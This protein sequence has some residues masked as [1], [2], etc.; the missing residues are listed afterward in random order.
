[1]EHY[2]ARRLEEAEAG[3]RQIL[4]RDPNDEHAAQILARVLIDT[5]RPEQALYMLERLCARRPESPR[6]HALRARALMLQRRTEEAL[7]ALGEVLRL[8]PVSAAAHA[9]LGRAMAQA[10][11]LGEARGLYERAMELATDDESRLNAAAGLA[12]ALTEAGRIREALATARGFMGVVRVNH[13]VQASYAFLL[14]YAD[15]VTPRGVFEAHRRIGE[16]V[17]GGPAALAPPEDPD[18]DPERELRVGFISPDFR[19]HSVAFFVEPLIRELRGRG[20]ELFGYSSTAWPDETT[21][22]F[23]GLFHRFRDVYAIDQM[24]LARLIRSDRI[25]IAIDLTGLVRATRVWALVARPAPIQATYCG[26]PNTT[27]LAAIDYRI[28]DSITDPPG[29]SDSLCVERLARLPGCFLCYQR[30]EVAPGVVLPRERPVVFGSFNALGKL[31][32]STVSLWSRLLRAVPG[33]R[34]L[35]KSKPLSDAEVRGF[36]VKRFEAEGIGAERLDLVGRIAER[37]EHLA[38]YAEVDV[39]LDPFPYNGTTTT[40]ES[41]WMGVPVVTLRLPPER[42]T[43][44]SRVGQSLLSAAGLEEFIAETP[45]EYVRKCE[46]LAADRG[47]RLELR[48]GLRERMRSSGLCDAPGH[49]ARFAEVLRGM[50]RGYCEG[51]A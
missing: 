45:E 3:A 43:H 51:R 42:A 12:N 40:C 6:Y 39:A 20:L 48:A 1:M 47:R 32:D 24:D 15:D 9:E 2:R 10:G 22:R 36:V 4:K 26:Y 14:N 35:L 13:L 21:E 17:S 11:R 44:A 8:E 38:Y 5:A 27:G 34:L 23:R 46:E 49:A 18:L 41:L 7:A 30:P 31:S 16:L 33:S 28:V 25:D 29:E 50:W 37:G 19:E